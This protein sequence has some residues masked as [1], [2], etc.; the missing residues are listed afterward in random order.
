MV[1]A[2]GRISPYPEEPDPLDPMSGTSIEPD[3]GPLVGPVGGVGDTGPGF[4]SEP[5]PLVPAEG[6]PVEPPPESEPAPDVYADPGVGGIESSMAPVPFAPISLPPSIG[7]VGPMG[8]SS[9]TGSPLRRLPPQA[10][11]PRARFGQGSP[12]TTTPGLSEEDRIQMIRSRL[13]V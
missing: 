12:I 9:N 8:A 11:K 7:G 1:M 4:P 6:S 2:G 5:P 3:S 10:R 13:G